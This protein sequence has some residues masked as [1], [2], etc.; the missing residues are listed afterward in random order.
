VSDE[1]K[2][3]GDITINP[4][5]DML[6]KFQK[7]AQEKAK[8]YE[9]KHLALVANPEALRIF[10]EDL[11]RLDTWLLHSEAI[12]YCRAVEPSQWSSIEHGYR[13]WTDKLTPLIKAGV[14]ATL[15]VINPDAKEK[16]WRVK[17]K[18]F[19]KWLHSKGMRPRKELEDVLKL[20][21]TTNEAKNESSYSEHPN[22]EHDAQ[23]RQQILEAALA[24]LA[25]YP[26]QC[27]DKG[28]VSGAAIARIM[29]EKS[30]LWFKYDD[31]P[32]SVRKVREL[33]NQ[34]LKLPDA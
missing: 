23:K 26:D 27:M 2:K 3:S 14:G 31:I 1:Q 7:S 34:A 12:P 13:D 9:K 16:D 6:N 25:N 21:F 32:L 30:T 15:M 11:A 8:I 17:P 4:V 20:K 22:A 19:V 5:M 33:I 28:K 24:I 10:Y 18:E 29:E